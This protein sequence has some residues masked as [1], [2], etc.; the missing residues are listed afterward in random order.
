MAFYFRPHP[1]IP[2]RIPGTKQ[3]IAATDITRRFSV[4]NFVRNAGVNFDEYYVQDGER[5]DTVAYDYYDDETMDWLILLANEIHDP[6]YEWPLSYE[7]FNSYLAQKYGTVRNAYQTVHHYEQIL[8][9]QG[10]I[11]ESGIQRLL[12]EKTLEIDYTTYLTL[13]DNQR[14]SVSVFDYENNLNE[15]RRHI[16]LIDLNYLQLIKEQ[17]PYI[18]EEGAFVR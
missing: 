2:Y 13:P 4:A 11:V 3:T 12:P 10:L 17:H 5:P 16:Y 7:Q 6:Y 18:F 1:T 15:Q 14:K 9:S 8:Q